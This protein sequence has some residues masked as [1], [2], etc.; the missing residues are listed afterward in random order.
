MSVRVI[1]VL[2]PITRNTGK[3]NSG[4]PYASETVSVCYTLHK[5]ANHRKKSAATVPLANETPPHLRQ[6]AP[7]ADVILSTKIMLTWT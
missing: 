4:S 7:V 5:P 2:A 3:R 1:V 6:A